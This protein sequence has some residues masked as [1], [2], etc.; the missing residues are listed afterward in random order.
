MHYL[1]IISVVALAHLLAVMS[2]GIDFIMITRTSLIY[3]LRTGM[4]SAIGLGLGVSVHIFYCLVGIGFII[5]QSILLFNFIKLL[6]GGE[7]VI[8]TALWF[9]FVAWI[10]S[11]PLVK[12]KVSG[13]QHFAEKFIGVVLIALGI[14]VALSSK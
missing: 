1:P 12:N 13:I 2:P 9:I 7:M 6:M 11:H 3:S 5:S 4:Y 8:V 14:K 10:V